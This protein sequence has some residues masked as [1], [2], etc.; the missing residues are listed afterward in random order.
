MLQYKNHFRKFLAHFANDVEFVTS[1]FTSC[2]TAAV[3][4]SRTSEL[5]FWNSF[6]PGSLG[7]AT[8]DR[9]VLFFLIYTPVSICI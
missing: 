3:R 2:L 8:A 1:V 4:F 9:S 5:T 7:T 6:L